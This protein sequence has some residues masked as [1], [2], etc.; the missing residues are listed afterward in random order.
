MNQEDTNDW[1]KR[2]EIANGADELQRKL[3][4]GEWRIKNTRGEVG[5]VVDSLME[6]DSIKVRFG[7]D[8]MGPIAHDAIE[9]VQRKYDHSGRAPEDTGIAK[10]VLQEALGD[11]YEEFNDI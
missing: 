8:D 3:A 10:D 1:T 6:D 9:Y 4:G 7:D 11:D 5:T 2:T